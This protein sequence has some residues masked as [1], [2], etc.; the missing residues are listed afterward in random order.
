MKQKVLTI[1]L[2]FLFIF[3]FS[4]KPVSW[5]SADM[6]LALQKLKILGSVLYLAAHP[7][8]ENT[9]LIAWLSKD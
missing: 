3:S 6:Y 9:R 7:D 1:I 4:Q 2:S 5:S 8:D